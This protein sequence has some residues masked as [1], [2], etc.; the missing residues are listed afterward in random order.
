MQQVISK[1]GTP[2]AYDRYG[3]SGP[4]LIFVHGA[5]EHRAVSQTMTR[6]A[7]LLASDF[8]VYHYDR[9]GRGDSGDTTPYA[10][11][12]EIEDIDALVQAAGG[13]AYAMGM[14]SGAVLTLRAAAHGIGFRKIA[15]YEPPLILDDSRPPLPADYVQQLDV[16]THS[17]RGGD[18]VALFMTAAVGM[19]EEYVTPMR[20]EPF[21]AGLE[22]IAHTIAYDGRIMGNLMSGDPSVLK[23]FATVSVPTLVIG[24][25]GS[26]SFMQE[27]AQALATTLPNGDHRS[28]ADQTHDVDPTVLAPVLKEYFSS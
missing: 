12:R 27:G 25:T 18:A 7:E 1:D 3:S 28:L 6:L 5:T 17:G 4:A 20:S 21:W 2:I 10:I 23:P 15:L 19:P 8:T 14:S 22:A 26:P 24:G 16:M 11:E 9:R 13:S